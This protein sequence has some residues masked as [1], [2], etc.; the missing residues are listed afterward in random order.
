MDAVA[1]LFPF[2]HKTSYSFNFL[3]LS[4][5]E[6][7]GAVYVSLMDTSTQERLLE[8][9]CT[10]QH[11]K[12][13]AMFLAG[14]TRF[15]GMNQELL[16]QVIQSECRESRLDHTLTLSRYCLELAFETE[17]NVLH[18]HP[19]YTYKLSQYSP[20]FDFTALGYFIARS[21]DKWLL[22]LGG[23]GG[24]M[25]TTSGVDLLLHALH[26]HSGSSYTIYG[27]K[28]Y[29]KETEIA[30]R[31]LVGLPCH[32]LPLVEILHLSSETLQPLPVCLPG[33]I[34]KMNGLRTLTLWWATSA[35][36][37]DTLQAL[38]TAPTHTLVGLNLTYS[39]FSPPAM[40]ALSALLEHSKSLAGLWLLDC[41]LTDDLVG[42]LATG[43]QHR[44][45]ALRGVGLQGNPLVGD[46]GRAALDKCTSTNKE[47]T[48]FYK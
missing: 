34:S 45:P 47:M 33:L 25:Q 31:L 18:G 30:Q 3:H 39:Q 11:L 8:D 48:L 43:L 5:Q 42:L 14:I 37:A 4:I 27:I 13:I 1:E 19:R 17:V 15:K 29:H 12:N 38:A 26:N 22:Q 20:L 6:Y 7:L 32:T 41:H 35:T 2:K 40:E 46:R 36:L 21:Q 44:L 10:K 28:C 16:K 24:Y 23:L 9:M